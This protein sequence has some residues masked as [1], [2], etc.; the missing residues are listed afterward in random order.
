MF[1]EVSKHIRGGGPVPD[2]FNCQK[3]NKSNFPEAIAI[4]DNDLNIVNINATFET[5][6]QCSMEEVEG[7]NIEKTEWFQEIEHKEGIALEVREK[8]YSRREVKRRKEGEILFGDMIIYPIVKEKKQEGIYLICRD[9]SEYKSNQDNT[10]Y[11]VNRDSLTG[12][13]NRVFFIQLLLNK[14]NEAQGNKIALLFLDFDNFRRINNTLGYRIGDEI[15]KIIA[16]KLERT[17]SGKAVLARF[18]GNRFA[19]MMIGID[20]KDG[21]IKRADEIIGMFEMPIRIDS[22][23]IDM[24][25]SLGIAI[26]PEHG[27]DKETLMENAEIAM[28][29]AKDSCGSSAKLFADYMRKEIEEEFILVN[30]LK[31]ALV[32]NEFELH[33]QPIVNLKSNEVVGAE[34]L[35]RWRHPKRGFI[36]PNQFIPLAENNGLILPIGEW[37]MKTACLQNKKWQ[38]LG[39]KPI[40]M[41]VNVSAKQLEQKNFVEQIIKILDDTMLDPQFLEL[42]I[43]E[44]LYIKNIDNY[45]D[46][47]R[48]LN[49]LGVKI[50]IDDF[51]TG[52]SSLSQLRNL[53]INRL[54][55]DKSFIDDIRSETDDNPIISAIMTIAK[56]LKLN[57]IAEGIETSSQLNYLRKI[58]CEMGQGYVLSKPLSTEGFE[59]LLM[60]K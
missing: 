39:C 56:G 10:G 17:L 53:A 24:S 42:E 44:S 22:Y 14:I 41:A 30:D 6:F 38:N 36:S 40:K 21:I 27:Q 46:D 11:L 18:S 57:V 29:R 49:Q 32:K 5:F 19:I 60:D 9:I 59:K 25:V 48:R 23:E 26:Y 2:S 7:Q 51:G 52:Y 33:Y 8:G 20:N 45:I 31:K 34:A 3:S 12:L 43:T 1:R 47:F 16:Y 37:V 28:Y 54:K 4:L 50:S 55:I 15:I 13:Y 35:L 58:D